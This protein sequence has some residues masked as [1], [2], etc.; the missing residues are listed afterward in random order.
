M[1]SGLESERQRL[2]LEVMSL[3]SRCL[4]AARNQNVRFAFVESCTGGRLSQSISAIDGASEVFY[5]A[6][7][8][9]QEMAKVRLLDIHEDI[10]SGPQ[11]YSSPALANT[12]AHQFLRK[13]PLVQLVVATTGYT[14]ISKRTHRPERENY[15]AISISARFGKPSA[16]AKSLVAQ[17]LDLREFRTR[18]TRMKAVVDESLRMML[19][20]LHSYE[21][22]DIE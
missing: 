14:G 12:M 1:S 3:A 9:Y 11:G 5:G 20:V 2:T 6:M 4:D 7:I 13:N 19:S 10:L 21:W 18:S 16:V 22:G 8:V 17:R 15:A